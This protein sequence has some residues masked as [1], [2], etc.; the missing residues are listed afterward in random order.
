MYWVLGYNTRADGGSMRGT[1]T[2]PRRR[3]ALHADRAEHASGQMP[4]IADDRRGGR[5]SATSASATAQNGWA[6]RR[7]ALDNRRRRHRRGAR[8]PH[9]PTT[10]STS[11]RQAG[12]CRAVA[13][14][15][16][17]GSAPSYWSATTRLTAARE[18]APGQRVRSGRRSSLNPGCGHQANARTCS[19]APDPT[20]NISWSPTAAAV[21]RHRP[22]PCSAVSN[23]RRR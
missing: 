7:C 15:V 10:S 19:T 20:A 17:N 6:L 5:R 23:P 22:G 4:P 18:P 3:R 21:T 2:T 9:C 11:P 12:T 14:S 1:A 8:T 13:L 16:Q